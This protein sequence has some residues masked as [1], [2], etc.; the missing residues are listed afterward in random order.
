MAIHSSIV[1]WR[2]PWTEKPRGLQYIGLQR[3]RH[4]WSNLARTH[5]QQHDTEIYKALLLWGESRL[6]EVEILGMVSC[7]P[8]QTYLFF[9][10]FFIKATRTLSKIV[11]R[12]IYGTLEINQ[13]L[14]QSEENI[15]QENCWTSVRTVGLWII[16][17]HWPLLSSS[18]SAPNSGASQLQ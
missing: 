11:W 2:I 14:Q 10:F 7:R 9:F 5:A 8:M 15:F 16:T 12:S 3:V 1:A 18:I 4:N 13:C 6:K 17:W